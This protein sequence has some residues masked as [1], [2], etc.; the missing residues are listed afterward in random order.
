[1]NARKVSC[2]TPLTRQEEP[3]PC[4]SG[5]MHSKVILKTYESVKLAGL[6]R[7]VMSLEG[8]RA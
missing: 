1:V 5:A 7:T 4:S 6:D 3:V 2:G 8:E